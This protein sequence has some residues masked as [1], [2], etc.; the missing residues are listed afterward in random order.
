VAFSPDGKTLASASLDKLVRLWDVAAGE[1]TATLHGHNGS[2]ECVAW[3]PLGKLVASG[4]ADGTIRVWD[5][6]TG[7][8]QV[9]LAGHAGRIYSVA[10]RSG[11]KML[12]S[13]G[14][15]RRIDLWDVVRAKIV[16]TL[17]NDAAVFSVAFSPSGAI[18]AA[19]DCTTV[20]LWDVSSLA[21]FAPSATR[22]AARSQ[23]SES[24]NVAANPPRHLATL[25]GH[26]TEPVGEVPPAVTCIAFSPDRKTLASGSRDTTI[27]LWGVASGRD[28][29]TLKGHSAAITCVAFSL[30]GRTLAS[31]SD[32]QTVCLWTVT[33]N[34]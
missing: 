33:E 25:R 1:P 31:A 24:P 29:A 12:A 6:K 26:S 30:D 9:T 16:M 17:P 15:G 18:L 19:S 3:S 2:V 14:S 11:G 8:C 10:W 13:G 21:T 27:K 34:P 23:T 22:V 7:T 32:D 28:L 4:S 20:K 5:Q